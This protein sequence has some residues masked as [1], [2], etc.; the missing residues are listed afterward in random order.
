MGAGTRLYPEVQ[1][2]RQRDTSTRYDL[3]VNQLIILAAGDFSPDGV[4][5]Y[6]L[7]PALSFIDGDWLGVYQPAS[8]NSVVR[9]YH[10]GQTG[11][12]LSYEL[13]HNPGD[14]I[15]FMHEGLSVTTTLLIHAI[16]TGE[17][18]SNFTVLYT[19]IYSFCVSVMITI[20]PL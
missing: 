13:N 16:T 18:Y 9:Y 4:V 2:W 1:I 20:M 5:Q 8:G 15:D 7:N 19:A 17:L 10:D 11:G 12:P 3:Q 14:S 6:N